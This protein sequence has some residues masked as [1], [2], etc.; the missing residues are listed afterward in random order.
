MSLPRD[1]LLRFL[2]LYSTLY[3]SF[4]FSSPFLP[5]F[6]ASR[7][8]DS[9][10]LGLLLGAGTAVRLVS[11]PVAGRFADVFGSF[12]LELAL[13][14]IS[15]AVAS[16]LY[17]PAHSFWPLVLV[18]LTQ[19]AMLA[20]LAPLSDALAL[21]WST[22][23]R[24]REPRSFEYGWVRGGGSAAFIAG[25]L[26]A[27]QIASAW[28]LPSVLLI[29]AAGLFATGLSTRFAPD[30]AHDP[31]QTIRTQK[32]ID[33]D[34]VDLLRQPAF[35]RMVLA[36]ALVLG[37]H[38]MHDAFAIIRWSD[39]GISPAVSSVL[40]SESVAAEVVVFVLFGPR[41]L[42][43]LGTSGSLA[44]GAGAA[45]VR[46]GVMAQTANVTALAAI[47]PLHGLTF[48]LF[49]LACMRIIA[50]TVPRSVAG[51]A[52]AFYGTVAI[53]GTTAL[54]TM[55]SGWLFSRF[56]PS[57]FWAMASLCCAALPIIWSL[58]SSLRNG[59]E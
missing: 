18:T 33:R 8:V 48:A 1:L 47:E 27:G 32:L 35:V 7:G 21:S 46:W 43:V 2:L 3:C 26:C 9:E 17:L 57:G 14:A 24:H 16:L 42:D 5:A 19:A 44:L 54:L 49:H 6:L 29:S 15:A 37:S 45:V 28:G 50:E 52:Q 22:S 12:R 58:R 40:W 38:A 39:A 25:A 36:A 30:L 53:G 11:A 41:L 56:G 59:A 31:L 51:M 20:P 34:W 10:W 4:G 13:F 23:A 55:V